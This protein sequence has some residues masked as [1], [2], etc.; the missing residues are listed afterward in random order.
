MVF[1]FE[2]NDNDFDNM[3]VKNRFYS[4]YILKTV[5]IFK[6]GFGGPGF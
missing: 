4:S 6:K 2:T 3:C 5:N 1:I